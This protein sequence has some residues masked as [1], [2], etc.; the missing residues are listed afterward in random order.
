MAQLIHG[1]L[2]AS[3]LLFEGQEGGSAEGVTEGL[4]WGADIEDGTGDA[5]PLGA[6]P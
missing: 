6:T 5:A 4:Q 3:F 2:W 1:S